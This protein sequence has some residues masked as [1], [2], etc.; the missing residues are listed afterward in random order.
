NGRPL[1]PQSK[2]T[3]IKS[4]IDNSGGRFGSSTNHRRSHN[5]IPSPAADSAV[6]HGLATSQR[7]KTSDRGRILSSSTSSSPKSQSK[8]A[9][10]RAH[11]AYELPGKGR[12]SSHRATRLASNS[13]L[14]DVEDDDDGD[15]VNDDEEEES[16]SDNPY[17]SR[18]DRSNGHDKSTDIVSGKLEHEYPFSISKIMARN[19]ELFLDHCIDIKPYTTVPYNK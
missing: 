5:H 3:T 4:N 1:G 14:S 9:S 11:G 7:K 12:S 6:E 18:R 2:W 13:Y 19:F 17:Y 15:E 8:V 16:D 10:P